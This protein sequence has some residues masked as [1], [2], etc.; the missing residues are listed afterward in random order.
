MTPFTSILVATDFSVDGNNAVRRAALLAHQHGA[1]LHILHVLKEAACRPLRDW[2]SPL[3][4]IDLK[5]ALARAALRRVAVEIAGAYDVTA[6][7]EVQVGDPLQTLMQA[8]AHVDLVV[9]GRRGHSRLESLLIGRTAD[10]MLRTCRQPVLVVKKPADA[11]YR[12]VLMPMDFTAG[13]DAAVRLGTRMVGGARMHVF[14]AADSYMESMLRRA[15]V[16][17][18]IIL[19]V[20]AREESGTLSRMRRML[21]RLGVDTRPVF[22]SV[23]RG[24]ADLATLERARTLNADLIVAGKNG[25]STL[26]AFLLGSVSSS[27]LSESDCDMLIVPQPRDSTLPRVESAAVAS[28]VRGATE[29][30]ALAAAHWMQKTP[31]FVVR[32]AS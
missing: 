23:G 5:A 31:G 6:T 1:S 16:A 32:R 29:S 17:S 8:S 21:A 4:D 3:T 15:G 22:F 27:V 14:H 12:K 9:L 28:D 30:E 25:R 10:R 7:V 20:K 11:P 19:D 26:G 2:F 18:S 24:P 13:S